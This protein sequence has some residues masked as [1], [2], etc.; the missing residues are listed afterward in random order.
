MTEASAFWIT[1]P[2]AG[3]IRPTA[4]AQPGADDVVVRTLRSGIS[5]GTELLVFANRVPESQYQL[6]RAPFMEG[7]FP[8]PVKYGYCNVGIVESGPPDVLG[9]RVFSLFPHQDRFVV[10]VSAAIPI[11]DSVP[12]ARAVLAAQLETAVNCVWD[13]ELKI[14]DR[15]AV[16]GLGV[17]GGLVA[18]LASRVPG[19]E[20]TAFDTN[21][22]RHVTAEA[23]GV[24]FSPPEAGSPP[25]GFDVVFHT[26]A[27]AAGLQLALELGG[28]EARI[29][30]LSWYGDTPVQVGLGEYFHSRRLRLISSQVGSLPASQKG[31]WTLRR[32]LELAI[33]LLADPVFD[34][35]L[36]GHSPFAELPRTMQKLA[37]EGSGVF[38]H[39][40]V[41]E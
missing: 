29:V 19:V 39:S 41:Y 18:R 40:I 12:S 31:R 4:V 1:G 36:S 28:F 21:V 33:A 10:P 23:L 25:D 35:F 13:A 37:D 17:I 11:P 34:L 26:S 6:M 8:A 24:G 2:K 16:V 5:K 27:A 7:N 32:R 20:V 3:E 15:V 30:E 14:G 38:C 22:Q 9:R